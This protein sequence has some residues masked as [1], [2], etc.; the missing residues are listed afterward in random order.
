MAKSLELTDSTNRYNIP[1]IC[2]YYSW[3]QLSGHVKSCAESSLWLVSWNGHQLAQPQ[4]FE[5]QNKSE[6]WV[7][8]VEVWTQLR[9][10]ITP[11]NR[12]ISRYLQVAAGV[13]DLLSCRRWWLQTCAGVTLLSYRWPSL[14]CIEL[15]W[16]WLNSSPLCSLP[17]VNLICHTENMMT[18]SGWKG[19]ILWH[20]MP[21]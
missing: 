15:V 2:H 13:T 7:V 21:C 20:A 10:A 18:D 1:H 4:T 11:K 8:F 12:K 5:L 6:K 9:T 19:F 3:M 16:Q 14:A 17:D